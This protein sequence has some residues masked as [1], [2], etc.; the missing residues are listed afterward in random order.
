MVSRAELVKSALQ[1]GKEEELKYVGCSQ[2]T[3]SAVCKAFR[4]AGMPLMDQEDEEKIF[5]GMIGL[6]GG[7]GSS[8]RGSCGACSGA[9][10][11]VSW[12]L[13]KSR[14]DN[15]EDLGGTFDTV[16]WTVKEGIVDRFMKDY[17]SCVCRDIQFCRFGNAI[18]FLS[19]KGEV[20]SDFLENSETSEVCQGG[21]CTIAKAAAWAVEAICDIK[22]IKGKSGMPKQIKRFRNPE[23][24]LVTMFQGKTKCWLYFQ[25]SFK[26]YFR[27]KIN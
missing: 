4:K 26:A 1:M 24:W 5:K 18:D 8:A 25:K 11:C 12:A 6:Q 3:F 20:R 15:H 17:G 14:E 16:N 7:C 19:K 9:A 27:R 2:S 22:G 21:N 13:D 10:F 23:K